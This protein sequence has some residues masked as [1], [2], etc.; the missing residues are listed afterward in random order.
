MINAV[1]KAEYSR[2]KRPT[3]RKSGN[4]IEPAHNFEVTLES[5]S[6]SKEK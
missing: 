4:P 5:D 3:G 1:H 2:V 6:F